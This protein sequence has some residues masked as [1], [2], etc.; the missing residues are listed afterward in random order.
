MARNPQK[1]Q[2]RAGQVDE[3]VD[4]VEE[5]FRLIKKVH[6]KNSAYD[7]RTIT[8]EVN[9]AVR[10]VRAKRAS[11]LTKQQVAKPEDLGG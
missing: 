10:E 9:R 7:P 11:S 3:A 2:E 1:I 5:F 6:R 4:P 8:R